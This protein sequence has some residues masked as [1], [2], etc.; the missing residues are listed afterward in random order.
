MSNKCFDGFHPEILNA[1]V[2]FAARYLFNAGKAQSV[3]NVLNQ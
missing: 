3:A 2:D 1:R